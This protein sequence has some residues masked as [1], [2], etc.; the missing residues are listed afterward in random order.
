M[1]LILTNN[2]ILEKTF[3]TFESVAYSKSNN[4]LAT[5][6]ELCF[7]GVSVYGKSKNL[8]HP[9]MEKFTYR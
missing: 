7:P 5:V 6:N 4:G 2:R 8:I 9:A 1:V 3:F